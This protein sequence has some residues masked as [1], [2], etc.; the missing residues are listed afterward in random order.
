ME[1][2]LTND[3]RKLAWMRAKEFLQ[4]IS[5]VVK[6]EK[7]TVLGSFTTKKERPADVD[8]IVMVK[9]SSTEDWSVDMQF[10]P[11]NKFGEETIQDANKWMEEKYG[12]GNYQ[13]FEFNADEL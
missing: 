3:Y 8:F 10:V 7:V 5:S 12:A 1:E 13:V 11:S 4:K 9:T 6:I 2:L